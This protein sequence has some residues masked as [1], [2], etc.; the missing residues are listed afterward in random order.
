M[1]KHRQIGHEEFPK[2]E[3]Q[4]EIQDCTKGC[5]QR[6]NKWACKMSKVDAFTWAEWFRV[7]VFWWI[8]YQWE[9]FYLQRMVEIKV[10]KVSLVKKIKTWLSV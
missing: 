7:D 3:I 9:V 5:E 10:L 6:I 4:E 8:F 1:L 2:H